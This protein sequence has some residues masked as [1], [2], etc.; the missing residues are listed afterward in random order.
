M[1]LD[2]M[3]QAKNAIA[4]Y[5]SALQVHSSNIAN[6]SVNGYKRLDV[7][8]QSI[9]ESL[10]SEGSSA[11]A[12]SNLGGTNPKQFGQGVGVAD[13]SIDMTQ[14][15][16]VAAN[17]IDLAIDG[18]GLFIVSD[19]GGSTYKYTR[20]GKFYI[21]SGNLLTE[22]GMQVYGLNSSGSVVPISGLTGADANY[23]WNANGELLL[24]G[25][26]TGYRVALTYFSNSGGLKQVS[27]TTFAESYSSG[28]PATALAPGGAAG[29]LAA[30]QIEQSNVFYLGESIDAM[31]IQRAMSGNLT[32]VRMAS[33]II[34]QFISKIG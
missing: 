30:G 4:S 34:S 2:I 18:R 27:G 15:S 1:L 5:N 31:G 11:S 6:M 21:S 28:A 20:A 16:F 29:T 17:S 26:A 19:D 7:S 32:I 9:F 10:L 25:A 22:S 33:D 24:N 23:S 8:F 12:F 13:V 14:G 3:N